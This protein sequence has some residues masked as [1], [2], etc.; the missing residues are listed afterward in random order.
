MLPRVIGEHIET[1]TRLMGNLSLSP[2]PTPSQL[3]QVLVN[4]VLNCARRDADG[5]PPRDRDRQRH[6][7]H[8]S[9]SKPE[10]LTPG[11][12]RLR[13]A[14]GQRHRHRHG[15]EHA[16]ACLRA[17]LHHQAEGQGHRPRSRHR[18]RHRRP[19]RRRHRARHRARPRHDGAHLPAGHL[20]SRSNRSGRHRR[21]SKPRG[22][23]T[24]L[25]VEDNDAVRELAVR[26]LR[27][28]GYTVFEARNAEEAIEWSANSPPSARPCWSP[29]WSCPG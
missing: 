4:L 8:R 24:L 2:A 6:A 7:R 12:W 5:R 1:T 23:E 25:L 22:T 26:S 19:E 10:G 16:G 21:R 15:P 18:L 29:T 17:V 9:R 11:P 14:R 20:G 28:R 13:D 27:R 3:E